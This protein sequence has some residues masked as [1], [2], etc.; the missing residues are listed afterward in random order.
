MSPTDD[1]GQMA[2][3]TRG[4]AA[5][6]FAR[7]RSSDAEASRQ[8]F[9]TWYADAD[10]ARAYEQLVARWE[11][12]A[13]IGATAT[14]RARSLRRASFV[15]R[16]PAWSAAAA[17]VAV[18]GALGVMTAGFRL[19]SGPT[20]LAGASGSERLA[21]GSALR[22]IVLS[23]GSRVTLDQA[24]LVLVS[25]SPDRRVLSLE[26]GRARFDVAHDAIRPFVVRAGPSEVTARGTL[27]D[28]A[29]R[30]PTATVTL[31]RG[32]IEVRARNGAGTPSILTAGQQIA[33]AD[34]QSRG[35]VSAPADSGGWLPRMIEFDRTPLADA[36]AKI[37]AA[38]GPRIILTGDV[39]ALRITGG[40]RPGDTAALAQAAAAMFD[41]N[42]DRTAGGDFVLSRRDRR[43]PKKIGG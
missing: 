3:P 17:L 26:R 20:G 6:W 31:I 41:L 9:E 15:V 28:V 8:A 35:P 27:F 4:E 24:S 33:V 19:H 29:L 42:T 22:L 14:G 43:A 1:F 37:E 39:G 25:Y 40:F 2:E 18:I 12:S 5:Y 16:H 23:D 38:A 7:M 13:F 34:A 10:N 11:Q 21:S 36:S 30:G 32:V